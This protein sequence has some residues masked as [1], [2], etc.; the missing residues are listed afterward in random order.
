MADIIIQDR[1]NRPVGSTVKAKT[2]GDLIKERD[3][4][5]KEVY[6]TVNGHP[7]DNKYV[8][9]DGDFVSIIGES[10]KGA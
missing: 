6:V 9:N 10:L 7:K 4:N 1:Q 3:L 2:V 5:G 8:L